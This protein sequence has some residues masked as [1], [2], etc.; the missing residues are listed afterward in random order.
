MI[1]K[2]LENMSTEERQEMYAAVEET[3]RQPVMWEKNVQVSDEYDADS[4]DTEEDDMD[5]EDTD[6]EDDTEDSIGGGTEESDD[7]SP[8]KNPEY[9]CMCHRT[10]SQGAKLMKMPNNMSICTDCMQRSF[11]AFS[12]G[13]GGN[14]GI[15]F[16][17]L[18]NMDMNSLRNLNL[19]DL[20]AGNMTSPKIKA[21]KAKKK[22]R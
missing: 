8:K 18:S 22:S 5:I 19:G 3:E 2:E 4:E 21:K 15:Q 9:C 10:E 16:V 14:S 7:D 20:L 12:S 1:E 6:D 17:D 11:D 13:F